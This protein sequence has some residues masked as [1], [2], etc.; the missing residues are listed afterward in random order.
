MTEKSQPSTNDL[1][2]E[3]PLSPDERAQLAR[4]TAEQATTL[5]LLAEKAILDERRKDLDQ[6]REER[7]KYTKIMFWGVAIWLVIVLAILMASGFKIM[8]FELPGYVLAILL[9]GTIIGAGVVVGA[10]MTALFK[11]GGSY[12]EQS[13]RR[14]GERQEK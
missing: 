12:A 13:R 8:S 3:S 7:K 6:N 2:E 10:I 9:S 4:L 1:G 5:A 14:D 11:G